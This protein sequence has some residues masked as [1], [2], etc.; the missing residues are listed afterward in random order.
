MKVHYGTASLAVLT[1]FICV[2]CSA[3][4]KSQSNL[5]YKVVTD[6]PRKSTLGFSITPPNGTNWFEGLKA[7]SLLY[8]KKTE[9]TAYSITAQATELN[10]H[11]AAISTDQLTAS[12]RQRKV[13]ALATKDTRNVQFA[14]GA[15]SLSANCIRYTLTYDAYTKARASSS[16]NYVKNRDTG[17]V[18]Y[19]PDKPENG[20]EVSYQEKSLAT[21]KIALA[22]SEGE[23]FLKSLK[24]DPIIRKDLAD[25]QTQ[26]KKAKNIP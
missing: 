21:Q 2:G 7:N 1:L 3:A 18:C 17:K 22:T 9:D 16:G 14:S 20:I 15:D 26:K 12:T 6:T 11:G 13:D 4:N 23:F 10:L 25:S 19:H 24:I 8:L 5:Y